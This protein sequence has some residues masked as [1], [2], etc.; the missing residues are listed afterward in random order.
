[1]REFLLSV[2]ASPLFGLSA[3]LFAYGIGLKLHK[4][5]GSPLVNPL[6]IAD[7]LLIAL[8]LVLGIPYEN[9]MIGGAFWEMLLVPATAIL[10][11]KIYTQRTIL[12]RYLVPVLIGSAVGALVAV[13]CVWGLSKLFGLDETLTVSLLPKSVTAAI[14]LPLSEQMGGINSITTFALVIAGV[15]GAVFAPY[16][17]RWFRITNPV[18]SGLALGTASHIL[19]TT[20]AIELGEVEGALSSCAIGIAGLFTVFILTFF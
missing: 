11:T 3:T 1:M 15:S 6:L 19:G 18:A 13:V 20:K 8:L 2:T 5:A 16:W 4:K 14:A 17:I 12:K 9:Y 7:F 10:A